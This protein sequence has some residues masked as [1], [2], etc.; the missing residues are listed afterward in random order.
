[1]DER[2]CS[3]L[4]DAEYNRKMLDGIPQHMDWYMRRCVTARKL[5][6]AR[7]LFE[8]RPA[9]WPK[10]MRH[11]NGTEHMFN[12]WYDENRLV[13]AV[14]ESAP[15]AA[16]MWLLN[17]TMMYKD[18]E[19]FVNVYESVEDARRREH[20]CYAAQCYAVRGEHEKA[21]RALFAAR[22]YPAAFR[23]PEYDA[24]AAM[25]LVKRIIAGEAEPA[26]PF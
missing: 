10:V 18:R 16:N 20:A 2:G 24:E 17:W 25:A 5:Y 22:D 11:V 3:R 13:R 14:R 21:M 23:Q 8:Q 4:G 12:R 26:I 15:D 9:A 19:S 6:D 7:L 1:M